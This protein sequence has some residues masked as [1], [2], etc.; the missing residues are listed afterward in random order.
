MNNSRKAVNLR[1]KADKLQG[2]G[3]RMKK[4]KV[5]MKQLTIR[6]P[7]EVHRALKVRA[8]EEGQ[9]IAVLVEGLIRHYLVKGKPA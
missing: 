8:A 5:D 7:V 3:E 9:S 2:Q 4:P 6:V 1:A